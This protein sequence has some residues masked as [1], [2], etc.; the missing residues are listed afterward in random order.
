MVETKSPAV[1][2]TA[3]EQALIMALVAAVVRELSAGAAS[4]AA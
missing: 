3:T 1:S 2:F 4:K